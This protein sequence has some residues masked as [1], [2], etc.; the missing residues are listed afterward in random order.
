M[1][2]FIIL[3]GVD[4]MDVSVDINDITS[5]SEEASS[6]GSLHYTVVHYGDKGKMYNV[7]EPVKE[8]VWRINEVNNN[9]RIK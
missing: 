9:Q 3:T 4:N 5:V 7:K 8:I 2:N 1:R 6:C